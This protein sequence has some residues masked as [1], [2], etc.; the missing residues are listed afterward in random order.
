MFAKSLLTFL[1]LDIWVLGLGEGDEGALSKWNQGKLLKY[2]NMW[3]KL[4]WG[5]SLK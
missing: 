4:F 2:L 3:I 5:N 1:S